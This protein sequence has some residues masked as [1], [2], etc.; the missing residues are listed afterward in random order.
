MKQISKTTSDQLIQTAKQ[1]AVE[2]I[3][4][5]ITPYEGGLLIWK[6]CQLKL[7]NGD[8]RLDPFVYWSSEF[9]DT[10]DKE[11]L[12]LCEHALRVAADSLI[13]RGTAL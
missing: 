5:V 8:H 3:R 13:S 10:S 6:E 7:E 12:A 2:I 1:Y 9:E 11:R 4:G